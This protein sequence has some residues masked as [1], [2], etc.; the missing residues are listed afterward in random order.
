MSQHEFQLF[1]SDAAW[2]RDKQN[3][4][5]SPLCF[6]EPA[7]FQTHNEK[8]HSSE[9]AISWLAF[10]YY[11]FYLHLYMCLDRK[12]TLIVDTAMALNLRCYCTTQMRTLT[13]NIL[14]KS[15]TLCTI[16]PLNGINWLI[17][18][19]LSRKTFPKLLFRSKCTLKLYRLLVSVGY[20]QSVSLCPNVI[21]L[22]GLIVHNVLDFP[23][24][25]LVSVLIWVV[26]KQRSFNAIRVSFL[27]RHINKC[28]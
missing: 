9:R 22:S 20:W 6:Q 19:N 13:R 23:W 16:K 5:R 27:S 10:A 1:S 28:H 8:C 11:K 15:K 18:S 17:G 7:T 4:R 25:F 21:P 3:L 2:K 12:E 26:Q 24:M 14:G